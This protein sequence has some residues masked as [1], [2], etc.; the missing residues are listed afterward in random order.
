M[1]EGAV[2]VITFTSSSTVTN[3]VEI[4][5]PEYALPPQVRIACIG[6]VTA[7][8]AQKAGFKIDIMQQEYTMEGLVK[9]LVQHFD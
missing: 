4:M 2:D 9:S 3:F 1:D 7:Q 6:P 5:G 8:T